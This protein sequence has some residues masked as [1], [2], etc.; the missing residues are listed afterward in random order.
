METFWKKSSD[1]TRK[2]VFN[3]LSFSVKSGLDP[4][5]FKKGTVDTGYNSL[6]KKLGASESLNWP[7]SLQGWLVVWIFWIVDLTRESPWKTGSLDHHRQSYQMKKNSKD[8][9]CLCLNPQNCCLN[10]RRMNHWHFQISLFQV[11]FPFDPVTKSLSWNFKLH[12]SLVNTR[13][14]ILDSKLR[15]NE[16]SCGLY[17]L[18]LLF[19]FSFAV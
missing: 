1:T 3:I 10:R 8:R 2:K 16:L 13:P 5:S 7:E 11:Y 9:H 6:D 19:D 17:C 12:C 4:V 14:F 18:N 15:I